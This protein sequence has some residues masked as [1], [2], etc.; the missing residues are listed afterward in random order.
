[1]TIS[2]VHRPF[3]A[4]SHLRLCKDKLKLPSRKMAKKP[5]ISQRMKDQTMA[6]AMEYRDCGVEQWK[7]MM[8][9]DE[10][11]FELHLGD[12][13]GHCRWPVGLGRFGPKFTKKGGQTS[14]KG[15]GLGL[16]LLAG[17]GCAGVPQEGGN[18]EQ[19]EVPE[20]A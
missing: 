14:S 1:M 18:D 4:L 13:H 11:H 19:L 3:F 15:H 9:S 12:K 2:G 16:S 7:D 8:F 10:S 17:Q 20:G 5:L 6:F